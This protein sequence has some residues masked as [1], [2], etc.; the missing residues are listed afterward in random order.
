VDLTKPVIYRGLD[1]NSLTTTALPS[2]GVPLGGLSIKRIQYSDVAG[3]GYREKRSLADGYDAG[4][5][6][7]GFRNVNI[8]GEVFGQSTNDLWDRLQDLRTTLTP[9][10]AYADAP[11]DLGFMDIEFYRPTGNLAEWPLSQYPDGIPLNIRARPLS[12]PSFIVD[13]QHSQGFDDYGLRMPYTAAL[14]AKDPL[15]YVRPLTKVLMSGTTGSGIYTNRGDYP[16]PLNLLLF[17]DDPDEVVF[18]FTGCGSGFTVTIPASGKPRLVRLDSTL[19]VCTMQIDTNEVLHMDL[20][21]FD[22]GFTWPRVLPS[23]ATQNGYS[24]TTTGGPLLDGS[25]AH[26]EEAFA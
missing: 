11:E 25:E 6:Y 13:E 4:T 24:W 22:S 1:L 7:L 17:V 10:L 12:Q 19:K 5:V 23:P 26:I 18:K 20:V 9:T 14:W 8:Q 2:A 15:I 16:A 21:D 3:E